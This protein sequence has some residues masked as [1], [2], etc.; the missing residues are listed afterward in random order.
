MVTIKNWVKLILFLLI[1]IGF[2]YSLFH[3]EI[4]NISEMELS[5]RD[6]QFNTISMSATIGG[7]LFTGVSILI[8]TL[9]HERIERLWKNNYFD[10]L[11]RAAFVG[12]IANVLTIIL[13]LMLLCIKLSVNS[14]SRIIFIELTTILIGIASFIWCIKQ[15]IF[16]MS[17]L[18]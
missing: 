12:M 6:F 1:I 4:I 15:L 7:F 17:K 10:N 18:K 9:N 5:S 14:A 8:S 3:W 16:I 13:A 11:Y 2:S